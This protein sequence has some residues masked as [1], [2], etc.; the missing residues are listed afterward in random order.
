MQDRKT[1]YLNDYRK[2]H[3]VVLSSAQTQ[4]REASYQTRNQESLDSV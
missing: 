1:G 3:Q 4:N 2:E